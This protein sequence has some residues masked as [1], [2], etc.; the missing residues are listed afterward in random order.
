M[1][2]IGNKK[3]VI[4]KGKKKLKVNYYCHCELND[5]PKTVKELLNDGLSI[6]DIKQDQGMWKIK[7]FE[8]IPR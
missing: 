8:I 3:S 4:S 5:I 6:K 7:Y 2:I 1:S